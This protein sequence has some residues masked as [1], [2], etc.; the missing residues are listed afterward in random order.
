VPINNRARISTCSPLDPALSIC[1]FVERSDLARYSTARRTAWCIFIFPVSRRHTRYG[2]IRRSKT[3]CLNDHTVR[4]RSRDKTVY[5]NTPFVRKHSRRELSFWEVWHT[6]RFRALC[7]AC[8]RAIHVYTKI[9][10]PSSTDEP[11]RDDWEPEIRILVHLGRVVHTISG[12]AL[13]FEIPV[14]P[15]RPTAGAVYW[16][17]C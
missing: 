6:S 4:G 9:V 5:D 17:T 3:I 13:P 7:R 1:G 11:S 16:I 12:L 10:V 2:S 8:M 15:T 14:R